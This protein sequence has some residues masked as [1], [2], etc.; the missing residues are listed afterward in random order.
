MNVSQPLVECHSDFRYAERPKAFTWEE[1]R[2]VVSD[3]IAQWRSPHAV[4]FR[5]HTETHGIFDLSY[6][7]LEGVWEIQQS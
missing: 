7:E 1:E 6:D 5:V 4:H 2:I 3:V